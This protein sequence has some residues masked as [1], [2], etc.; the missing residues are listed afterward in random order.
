MRRRD[1]DGDLV[2]QDVIDGYLDGLDMKA[3]ICVNRLLGPRVQLRHP[4][5]GHRR[6]EQ[7]SRDVCSPIPL[8]S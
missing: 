5:C 6:Y 4:D 1:C 2:V 7:G 8:P 3:D